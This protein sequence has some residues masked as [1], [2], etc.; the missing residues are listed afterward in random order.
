MAEGSLTSSAFD[1]HGTE[2]KPAA[3][4]RLSDWIRQ[5]VGPFES[6]Y[7]WNYS[8]LQPCCDA[9]YRR[10]TFVGSLLLPLAS[11]ILKLVKMNCAAGPGS[12]S[13]CFVASSS[14]FAVVVKATTGV[15]GGKKDWLT[16]GLLCNTGKEGGK[17]GGYNLS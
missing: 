9:R 5:R 17:V 1:S 13:F 11:T 15:I 16:W 6:Q 7:L 3:R 2:V 12:K 10:L 14:I 8:V 4:Y